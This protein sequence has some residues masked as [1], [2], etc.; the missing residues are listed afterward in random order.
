VDPPTGDLDHEQHVQAPEQHRVDVEEVAR[1]QALGLRGQE[2]LPGQ[3]RA[4]RCRI[5]AGAFEQQPHGARRDPVAE[6]EEFAVDAPIAPGRVVRCH[7]HDQVPQ[8]R[9]CR[10]PAG[11][12]VGTRPVATDQGSMPAQQGVGCDQA[13]VSALP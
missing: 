4:A 2:L 3:I 6:L 7:P 9:G 5:D 10:W 8:L 1:E 12:A 13:M 11:W